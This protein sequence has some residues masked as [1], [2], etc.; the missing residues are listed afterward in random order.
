[1]KQAI[2]ILYFAFFSIVFSNQS[3]YDYKIKLYGIS[4]ANCSV[5]YS[6]TILDKKDAIKIQYSVK[7]NKIIDRLFKI[8][9]DY[10]IILESDSYNLLYYKKNTF[11]PGTI[12]SI[13]TEIIDKNIKYKNSNI[14]INRSDKNIFSILS[15]IHNNDLN[16]LSDIELVER[17]GK[18][19]Y[20]KYNLVDG[21]KIEIDLSEVNILNKGLIEHTDIFLWGLF[22]KKSN[23]TIIFNQ[24]K[25]HIDECIFESGI[26]KITAKIIE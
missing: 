8:D 20:F 12:N 6:D 14:T 22:N 10:T 11:Q 24:D 17:E 19:Y 13:E 16:K 25:K 2:S 1:M 3:N 21:N 5:A 18:Y 23:K 9:N 15:I 26:I 4:V 7:T